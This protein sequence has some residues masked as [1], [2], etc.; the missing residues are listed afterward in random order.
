MPWWSQI[1][2]LLLVLLSIAGITEQFR[3]KQTIHA[4]GTSLCLIFFCLFVVAYFNQH[5]AEMISY[6]F[7][8]MLLFV[9]AYDFWLANLELQP[10][11]ANF[12]KPLPDVKSRLSESGALIFLL[13]AY[14]A[15]VLVI[16]RLF[17]D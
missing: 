5:V 11:S 16:Y 8:A 10:D 12:M 2:L 7:I 14:I 4:L 13:P 3:T 6:G 1:Y 9:L 17:N 15:G